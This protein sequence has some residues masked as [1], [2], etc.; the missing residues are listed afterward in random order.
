MPYLAHLNRVIP[1]HDLARLR[2][3]TA[4]WVLR[5]GQV[6]RGRGRV[7]ARPDR[8]LPADADA[9]SSIPDP[10]PGGTAIT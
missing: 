3:L 10:T 2:Y 1:K 7:K 5:Q 4:G 9:R 6:R 8:K